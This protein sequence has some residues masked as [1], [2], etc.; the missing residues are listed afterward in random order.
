M[1]PS[2]ALTLALL[3]AAVLAPADHAIRAA[4]P[5]L[6]PGDPAIY[7]PTHDELPV[8]F[9]PVPER[10][11]RLVGIGV[12]TI[13]RWY[14][15]SNPEVSDDDFTFLRL[16]AEVADSPARADE[17]FTDTVALWQSGGAVFESLDGVIGQRAVVGHQPFDLENERPSEHVLV[18]FRIGSFNG[19][20]LWGDFADLPNFDYALEMARL[21]EGRAWANLQVLDPA[22][23]APL[24]PA[25]LPTSPAP[26]PPVPGPEPTQAPAPAPA[27]P[28]PSLVPGPTQPTASSGFDPS[29]YVGQGDR[30]NC[31][32]FRSQAEAQAVLRADPSDPNRLDPDRDGIACESNAPPR[33][34]VRVPR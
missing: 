6:Q 21:I 10:D 16:L 18:F 12:T 28:A 23:A 4:A 19:G 34:T 17:V 7:L 2:F 26:P 24:P 32:D 8:G 22:Q 31:S 29:R 14:Q 11:V 5:G 25:P 15:R 30:Y 27:L 9:E 3:L 1:K 13:L 33:D 20:A